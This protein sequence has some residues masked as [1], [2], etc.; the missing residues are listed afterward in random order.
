M[1]NYIVSAADDVCTCSCEGG[2]PLQGRVAFAKDALLTV[3]SVVTEE[4]SLCFWRLRVSLLKH[5]AADC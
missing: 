3:R 5:L 4:H 1:S 2:T